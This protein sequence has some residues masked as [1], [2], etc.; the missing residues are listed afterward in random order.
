M[1]QL[2]KYFVPFLT[3]TLLSGCIL[4]YT[5]AE[6]SISLQPGD[7]QTFTVEVMGTVQWYLDGQPIEY[8][9]GTSYLF[10]AGTN[11][12]GTF[13]LT[14]TATFSGFPSSRTWT[15]SVQDETQT[16]TDNDG[17]IDTEDN[18]VDTSNPNQEDADN[19]GIGDACDPCTDVN[20]DGSCDEDTDNDGIPN[21]EDNCVNTSNPDQ[22]DADN[23]GIGD[24]CDPCTDAD[25][26]GSCAGND[27]D[28]WDPE[29]YPGNTEVCNNGIDDNCNGVVDEP[30]ACADLTAPVN[31]DAS[32]VVIT[33]YTNPAL[34]NNHNDKIVITWDSVSGA[35]YY[36][37]Y[38]AD[39]STG[40]YTTIG[41][42]NAPQTLYQDMQTE[43]MVDFGEAPRR[44]NYGTEEA[45]QADLT[46][47]EALLK[48]IMFGDATTNPRTPAFKDFKYYKVKAF[49]NG[50]DESDFSNYDE[51]RVD[52]TTEEFYRLFKYVWGS[53][54]ARVKKMD[55]TPGLGTNETLYG[56]IGGTLKWLVGILDFSGVGKT[57]M[58]W[59]NFSDF[60]G[61]RKNWLM[62]GYLKGPVTDGSDLTGPITVSDGFSAK[63]FLSRPYPT[64]E[65]YLDVT[66]NGASAV[67][68]YWS[69]GS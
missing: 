3:L 43:V 13:K 62:N 8:A 44:D 52:Y 41:T 36:R 66:Y 11:E 23:D 69:F 9:T 18:C 60:D 61:A 38:K 46:I 53:S 19:D 49:T 2:F 1:K 45:Y 26:D 51:G 64:G 48:K 54:A 17:I 5:P 21:V 65:G 28:D 31:V 25:N 63:I 29:R 24:V 10:S 37:V 55:P 32:D 33:S 6:T 30:S 20:Q 50:G 27:C 4:S 42:V 14:A 39:S 40:T 12:T 67:R 15:I 16:D 47:Y 22:E 57:S 58:T 35:D 59:T 56:A 34:N 7:S 68:F